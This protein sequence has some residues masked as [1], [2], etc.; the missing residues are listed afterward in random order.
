MATRYDSVMMALV[1]MDDPELVVLPTHRVGRR[2]PATFDPD[3]FLAALARDFELVGAPAPTRRADARRRRATR[4]RSS[5]GRATDARCVA[6]L[7]AD[8]DLADGDRRA[9]RSEAWKSLDVAVLQELVLSPL[10]DI[11]PDRPETLDRLR[12]VKERTTRRSR[13]PRSTTS[14]FVCA[15][16]GW[17]S[18]ARSPSPAR[19]MPQKSTYF[20]PKL[21][22]GLL[23]RDLAALAPS[24]AHALDADPRPP[25]A[26]ARRAGTPRSRGR[27]GRHHSRPT[28]HAGRSSVPGALGACA[29]A[30]AASIASGVSSLDQPGAQEH[31]PHVHV[32]G[33][34]SA[35]RPARRT[36]KWRV[37]ISTAIA[38]FFRPMPSNAESR[39]L[40]S[41]TLLPGAQMRDASPSYSRAGVAAA[42]DTHSASRVRL[43]RCRH[44]GARTRPRRRPA[45]TR[46][47]ARSR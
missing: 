16:R 35:L 32:V 28:S 7:R 27:R 18:C 21:L 31:A 39:S 36:P 25:R 46:A 38:A 5:C 14:T 44:G 13:R 34:A 37:R 10:L 30:A 23:M 41:V 1:N 19:L 26:R 17:T 45:R 9:T 15:R 22:S 29:R 47:A 8:V 3:A 33:D 2:A 42:A 40:T 6:R 12:F 20:Y 24:H 4:P 43:K 11:H